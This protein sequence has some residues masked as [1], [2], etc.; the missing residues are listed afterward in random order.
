MAEG[1]DAQNSPD[2]PRRKRG[3]PRKHPLPDPGSPQVKRGRGRPRK[4]PLPDPNAP[5]VP[6]KRGRPPKDRSVQEL[7]EAITAP[8]RKRGR[9]PKFALDFA[10]GRE[11]K[12]RTAASLLLSNQPQAPGAPASPPAAPLSAG[13]QP[14]PPLQE[15][16][17]GAPPRADD[18][19]H[20]RL[21]ELRAGLES[22]LDVFLEFLP[23]LLERVYARIERRIELLRDK[24][25]QRASELKS[26]DDEES[27]A[28]IKAIQ[29]AAGKLAAF[30]AE[31]RHGAADLA[32]LAHKLDKVMRRLR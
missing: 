12:R 23:K 16:E 15:T 10:A 9:P 2:P 19:A 1:S 25:D 4:H 18:L 27:D 32:K 17:G 20:Y 22:E 8:L 29:K 7:S 13:D 14:T 28:V 5:Q 31:G 30:R 6:R 26:F 24:L 21:L 11:D 3:R